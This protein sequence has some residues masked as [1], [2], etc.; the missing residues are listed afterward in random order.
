M[1]NY[2]YQ[3]NTSPISEFRHQP[4]SHIYTPTYLYSQYPMSGLSPQMP[5]HLL[6]LGPISSGLRISPLYPSEIS[7][8]DGNGTPRHYMSGT[9][10][11][12]TTFVPHALN[13]IDRQP[14]AST[15]TTQ[16]C[17]RFFITKKAIIKTM[18]TRCNILCE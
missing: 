5:T 9:N 16:M 6:W 10:V 17:E 7:V 15:D 12:Y 1:P 13:Y 18:P 14:S 4:L 3:N 8:R 2:L 11:S